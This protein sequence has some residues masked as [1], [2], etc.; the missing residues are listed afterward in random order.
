MK[1]R[2]K[3]KENLPAKTNQQ[4]LRRFFGKEYNEKKNLQ[5]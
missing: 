3:D 4:T 5:L 2:G 1:G